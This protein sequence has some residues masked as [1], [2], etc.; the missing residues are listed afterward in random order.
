MSNLFRLLLLLTTCFL[1][2]LSSAVADSL[3]DDPRLATDIVF[4]D[5]IQPDMNKQTEMAWDIVSQRILPSAQRDRLQHLRPIRLL[6]KAQPSATGSRIIF[7]PTRVWHA[8]E[9]AAVSYIPQQ[10]VFYLNISLTNVQGQS[11]RLSQQALQEYAQSQQETLGIQL[12]DAPAANAPFLGVQLI[13]T[14]SQTV[15]ISVQTLSKLEEFSRTQTIIDDPMLSMQQIV[16][17]ILTQARN[18]YALQPELA[19]TPETT[20]DVTDVTVTPTSHNVVIQLNWESGLSEQIFIENK[21]QSDPR[22]ISLTPAQLSHRVQVYHLQLKDADDAWLSDWF[23][24]FGFV[25]VR[26]PQGWLIQPR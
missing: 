24:R 11:M 14:D 7:N 25:A 18:A 17:D 16:L 4:E 20:T 1:S 22:V 3:T 12:V 6:L 5:G 10:P 26:Q 19:T 23:S 21:L 2:S 8:L 9:Q 13:W 15:Q